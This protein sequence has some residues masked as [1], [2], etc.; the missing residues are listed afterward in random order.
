MKS[1][2][3]VYK[4]GIRLLIVELFLAWMRP[5]LEHRDFAQPFKFISLNQDST[6]AVCK[7]GVRFPRTKKIEVF[8]IIKHNTLTND[9]TNIST[10]IEIVELSFS[11]QIINYLSYNR[12]M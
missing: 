8:C 11:S 10:M 7:R 3:A 9:C 6:V 5:G 2:V 4:R 1:M 12:I